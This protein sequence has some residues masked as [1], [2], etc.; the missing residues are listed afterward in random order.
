M[1]LITG[2]RLQE[3]ASHLDGHVVHLHGNGDAA[4]AHNLFICTDHAVTWHEFAS[5]AALPTVTMRGNHDI[6]TA[7]PTTS[8]ISAI[9]TRTAAN[10]K[11]LQFSLG[12][13]S[14]WS[15]TVVSIEMRRASS[16]SP[17][18]STAL[19]VETP[20]GSTFVVPPVLDW[21]RAL[22]CTI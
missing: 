15:M 6:H 10:V 17:N 14:M 3:F 11:G 22:S 12:T 1:Q 13:L 16:L 8:K 2:Q 7:L 5:S 4:V 20:V 19:S 9:C 21:V 18:C